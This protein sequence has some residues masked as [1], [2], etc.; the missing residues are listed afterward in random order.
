MTRPANNFCG[1]EGEDNGSNATYHNSAR[2]KYSKLWELAQ[3]LVD[4]I[5]L[6]RRIECKKYCFNDNG[7]IMHGGV[8]F[9]LKIELA[10]AEKL[11][12]RV[13]GKK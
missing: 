11:G 1:C 9:D 4:T 12:I 2:C 7:D 8:C 3:T 13:G 5:E 10:D 6:V